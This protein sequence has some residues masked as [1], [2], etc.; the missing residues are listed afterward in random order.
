MSKVVPAILVSYTAQG[1][2]VKQ[3]ELYEQKLIQ[4]RKEK[5]AISKQRDQVMR[6]LSALQSKKDDADTKKVTLL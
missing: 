3:R 4:E 5:D 6:D 1:E 2:L